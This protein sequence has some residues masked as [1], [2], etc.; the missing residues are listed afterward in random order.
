M[1][2][3]AGRVS[4]HLMRHP[5]GIAR[6]AVGAF[7]PASLPGLQLWLPADRGVITDGARQFTAA[8]S[9][10]FSKASE[11]ALQTGNV[12]YAWA[13][14]AYADTVTDYGMLVTKG[15]P[16]DDE[17]ELRRGASSNN[18]EFTIV[19]PTGAD[20][21]ATTGGEYTTGAWHLLLAWYDSVNQTINIRVDN[22]TVYS[23]PYTHPGT[24]NTSALQVGRRS[25][26]FYHDGRMDSLA[27]FKSP[28][29]G[30][31]AIIATISS[32]L[33]NSG[34]GLTYADLTAAERTDWGLIEWWD[35]DALSGNETGA[36]AG[37]VLTDNNTVTSNPGIAAGAAGDGDPE[38]QH[39]D[40]SGQGNHATQS[41]HA[42]KPLYRQVT[43]GGKTFFVDRL[44]GVDDH[45]IVANAAGLQLTTQGTI[46]AVINPGAS[47]ALDTIL[48]K[49]N[50]G[51][52]PDYLWQLGRGGDD[53]KLSLYD[54]TAWR[55]GT[56][57]AVLP[58]VYQ[59]VE[60]VWNGTTL[61]FL[62]NGADAGSI[63]TS[64]AWQ[65]S[66][67]SLRFGRQATGNHFGGDLREPVIVNRALSASERRSLR[68][69]LAAPCGITVS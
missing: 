38:K 57:G 45:L 54:G 46:M 59:V 8:N 28:P 21:I 14:Q 11:A 13:V 26:G 50:D 33:Y 37:L 27:L 69:Y 49:G 10:Y 53:G 6:V 35:M 44:D 47:T 63:S 5:T 18:A 31:A 42:A 58:N 20:A 67:D 16:A 12:D 65:T 43:N 51:G 60:L 61:Q 41:T 40:Y 19:R 68:R 56:A 23:K 64:Q 39:T 29:G 3:M 34:S 17:Y 32:R 52:D 9:E 66:T 48:C 36:H 22:G 1:T 7:T 25:D 30:I 62:V 4:R 2:I 55:D 24:T 15:T